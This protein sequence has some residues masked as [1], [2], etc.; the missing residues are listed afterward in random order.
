MSDN[1]AS[2]LTSLRTHEKTAWTLT[3]VH[4]GAH[5]TIYRAAHPDDTDPLA[6]K[7]YARPDRA[8][9]EYQVLR[10]LRDFGIKLAPEALAFDGN[11]VIMS[12][13]EGIP[14]EV[15]PDLNDEENW[16]R[17]MAAMGVASELDFV[18]YSQQIPM[19]GRGYLR[20]GDLMDD[21][22][23]SSNQIAADHPLRDRLIR[24]IEKMREKTTPDWHHPV[25][26]GLCRCDVSLSNLMLEG[27]CHVLALDWEVADWGDIA[28]EIGL[29][30]VHPD[31][32]SVSESHWV[33][34]RWEFAR[35]KNESDLVPRA[36][37]YARLGLVWW[38]VHGSSQQQERYL[39]RAERA[40]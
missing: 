25:S 3:A 36:T 31:Y 1:Y 8:A 6:V 17:L 33:W 26:A 30:S 37:L 11:T 15:L 23:R 18:T 24:V 9:R 20:P 32:E 2:L 14:F 21:I 28:A 39:K 4:Q 19:E 7:V 16:H 29:W 35:L 27:C 12:W 22:E 13:L 40:F 10:T 5:N 34:L 38:A